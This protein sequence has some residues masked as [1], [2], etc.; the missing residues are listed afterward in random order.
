MA[1]LS[2]NLV[3]TYR[4]IIEIYYLF[5]IAFS[6]HTA[7]RPRVVYRERP[8]DVCWH[9]LDIT[10]GFISSRSSTFPLQGF[11]AAGR[12]AVKGHSPGSQLDSVTYVSVLVIC[13]DS[14]LSPP[15]CY[16]LTLMVWLQRRLAII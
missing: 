16:C 4:R 14:L 15:R 6:S 12:S 9:F 7:F 2:L 8:A 10:V 5:F 3:Q 11:A 1:N 13:P